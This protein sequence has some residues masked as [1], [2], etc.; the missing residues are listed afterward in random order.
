MLCFRL[1]ILLKL[2]IFMSTAL[3]HQQKQA[4]T[5][6]K[7]NT[8]TGKTEVIHRF[9]LHDAEHGYSKISGRN[10]VLSENEEAQN[11]LAEYVVESFQ[12]TSLNGLVVPLYTVGYEAEGRYIWIYQE[13]QTILPCNVDVKMTAFHDVWDEHVNQINFEWP[14]GVKAV[15]LS[16]LQD[17]KSLLI[18]NCEDPTL[19]PLKE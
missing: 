1:I 19:T 5:V 13:A 9:Y 15:R 16:S 2:L 18:Y 17:R 3:S 14:E 8:N 7:P 11:E 6:I 12:L 4:Y 10:I